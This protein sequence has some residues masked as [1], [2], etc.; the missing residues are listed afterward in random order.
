MVGDSINVYFADAQQ[1][2]KFVTADIIDPEFDKVLIRVGTD[3]DGGGGGAGRPV[4]VGNEGEEKI[5]IEERSRVDTLRT[6]FEKMIAEKKAEA[7]TKKKENNEPPI[8]A[9]IVTQCA[10]DNPTHPY[11]FKHFIPTE[12]K[13][14]EILLGETKYFQAK[15]NTETNKLEI[16]EIIP[17]ANG[18]PQ[19]KT[20]TEDGW[21][22]L[23]SDVWE[24]NPV[25]VVVCD[26][27]GEKMGVYWEKKY[28]K[29]G[30]HRYNKGEYLGM[31][32]NGM[33]TLSDGLIRVIGR[34]WHK[35]S[36]YVVDLKAKTDTDDSVLIKIRVVKPPK[37]VSD[38]EEATIFG[39]Y[40]KTKDVFGHP[41]NIDSLCIYY[42]GILGVSPQLLKGQMHKET[43]KTNFGGDI[44]YGFAPTYRYE[45]YTTQKSEQVCKTLTTNPYYITP[46]TIVS[47]P[48]HQFT[49][50]MQYFSG[51][52][53]TVWQIVREYSQLV[54]KNNPNLYGSR[55]DVDTMD[56]DIA[57]YGN[58]DLQ[59]TYHSYF[60]STE[61]T[62]IENPDGT[63]KGI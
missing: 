48:D 3:L 8:E 55:T 52:T 15:R 57:G 11:N 5:V 31:D 41:V 19:Q 28:P 60:K 58:T 36:T 1:P 46:T 50:P 6:G 4:K 39:A 37:L 61:K 51:D 27:C 29:W 35:D 38:K 12:D 56:F 25:S 24:T 14:I 22:W 16:E 45:P 18:V 62:E 59:E 9:P 44:G 53:I 21:E 43:A 13:A 23:T 17:D 47:P 30:N 40:S 42:G 54:E 49:K 10:L 7:E 26:T 63:K 32:F 33:A 34:Y 20:G 2:I